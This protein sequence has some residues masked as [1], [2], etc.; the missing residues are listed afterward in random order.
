MLL[1]A[2]S[3]EKLQIPPQDPLG[4][5]LRWMFNLPGLLLV[6]LGVVAAIVAVLV[7]R[8]AWARR[9]VAA[10]WLAGLSGPGKA[11]LGGAALV[12]VVVLGAAGKFGFDYSMHNRN[13]CYACHYRQPDVHLTSSDSTPYPLEWKPIAHDTMSCHSC[14]VQTIPALAA[15]MYLWMFKR[16]T[17]VAGHGQVENFR[18][19]Q[20][21]MESPTEKDK[22]KRI[23]TTA[24]HKSHF[25]SDSLKTL[26]AGK[27][28]LQCV[29]CHGMEVHRFAPVDSTC[30]QNGCHLK[31]DVGIA[32]GKMANQTDLH[33]NVCHQFTVDAPL[34]ASRDSATSLIKPGSDQCFSCHQMRNLLANFR[35]EREPHGAKCGTCHNPHTQK[36]AEE[37]RGSC[38]TAGC[39]GDWRKIAFHTG[40]AHRAQMKDERN[41]VAC[42]D[43][44]ASKV[45]ASDCVGCHTEVKQRKGSRL[46]PPLPFDTA[47]ALRTSMGPAHPADGAP[48]LF[49][50]GGR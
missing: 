32:I 22:W 6:G 41:C 11:A 33:C 15:E 36:T 10:A 44:H 30:Y 50:R 43:A 29:T 25:E 39:H 42:H 8:W 26:L 20:C 47:K 37:V 9:S 38:A 7:L 35:E 16:P 5:F 28:G 24:G 27:G 49:A 1:Q 31:E 23:A 19:E 48:R 14:H 40:A 2:A 3:Q 21:H 13:F 12:L 18:C 45:D 46:D 34:L 17:S 4:E